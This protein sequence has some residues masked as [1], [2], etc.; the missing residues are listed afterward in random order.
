MPGVFFFP[1][2]E[3][4]LIIHFVKITIKIT[5]NAKKSYA[6]N[7]KSCACRN[8]TLYIISKV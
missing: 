5:Q 2:N 8:S 3:S 6:Q 7:I 4:T 1:K